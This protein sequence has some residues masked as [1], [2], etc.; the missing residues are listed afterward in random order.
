MLKK[1]LLAVAIVISGLALSAGAFAQSYIGATAGSARADID[2][3]GATSCKKSDTALKVFGG[4]DITPMFAVEA[5]FFSLGTASANYSTASGKFE[6]RG[7]EVSGLIKTPVMKGFIGFGKLGVAAI[8]AETTVT[9]GPDSGMLSK[10]S[11][12]A[13]YGFGLMYQLHNDIRLRS[14]IESRKVK[15]ANFDGSS[16]TVVNFSIGL[17]AAF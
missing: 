5:G 3:A 17:Q 1:N 15:A 12:Q 10:N 14:E 6:A 16:A 13:V 9:L 2:C 11:N 8:K 4:Y 7:I